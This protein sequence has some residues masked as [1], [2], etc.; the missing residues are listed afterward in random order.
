MNTHVLIVQESRN[1]EDGDETGALQEK[2]NEALKLFEKGWEI[3]SAQTASC[4]RPAVF[5]NV[6]MSETVPPCTFWTTTI[7]LKKNGK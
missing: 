4:N 3:V 2:V 5:D 6:D 1:G 7:L